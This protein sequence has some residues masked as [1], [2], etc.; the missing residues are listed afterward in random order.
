MIEHLLR[1]ATRRQRRTTA[2]AI[3]LAMVAALTGVALLALSGWFLTGAAIAGAGGVAGVR[4][5]NYLLPSAGIRGLAIART[6]SRYGERLFSH[7]AALFALAHLRPALFARLAATDPSHSLTQSSGD[8]A[9]RLG[10]DVDALEDSMVRKVTV[11]GA[12]A[13]AAAGLIAASLAGWPAALVL[14]AGLVTMRLSSRMLATR[15]LTQPRQDHA[16]ALNR[17]KADYASYAACSGEIAVYGLGAQVMAALDPHARALDAARVAIV[18]AEM[19]IQGVQLVLAALTVMGV[20]ALASGG[21]ALVALAAL[22]AAATADNWSALARSDMERMRVRDAVGRIETLAMLPARQA[23]AAPAGAAGSIMFTID[24]R[25]HVLQPGERLLIAGSS[26]SGKSRLLGTLIGLRRDAPESLAV[27]R[28]DVCTLGLESLRPLFAY[29]PQDAGLI[30]GTVADN[31]RL[32]RPGVTEAEMWEALE[33]A[34]LA[35]TVRSLPQGLAEWLGDNG[36]R[37]SGGQRKRLALARALLARKPWLVLD[38][39]SEGLDPETER[40]LCQRLAV[41]LNETGTG[42]VLV[43]HRRGLHALAQQPVT[44]VPVNAGRG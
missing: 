27:G 7:Q 31:L 3:G 23:D 22:A 19:L 6:L 30:A 32:S 21:A 36:A 10:S 43:S 15:L 9:A 42:L 2:I 26:G 39:P 38:E 11:P 16:A 24:G 25:H 41:W 4:A 1:D 37:L 20:L 29:V 18:R 13:G 34:C 17:L 14:L 5:F 33:T 44:L 28:Q 40:A 35:E 12:L 8:M